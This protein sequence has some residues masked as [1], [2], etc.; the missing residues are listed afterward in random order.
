[1]SPSFHY[2]DVT[3]SAMTSQ[4]TRRSGPHERK[5]QKLCVNGLC[6]GNPPVT[7]GFPI[8]RASNA[9]NFPFD[10]TIMCGIPLLIFFQIKAI[11]FGTSAALDIIQVLVFILTILGF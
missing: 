4:I 3:M 6:E 8:Q 9:E 7:D 11:K 1:M 2:S 10:D 5:H